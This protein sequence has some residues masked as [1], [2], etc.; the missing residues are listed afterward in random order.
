LSRPNRAEIRIVV[1][2][3]SRVLRG[4]G[5]TKPEH[6]STSWRTYRPKGE[7]AERPQMKIEQMLLLAETA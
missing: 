3:E 7:A 5:A 6:D 1:R 2:E 4:W